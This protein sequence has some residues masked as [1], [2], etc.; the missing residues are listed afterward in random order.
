MLIREHEVKALIIGCTEELQNRV[1]NILNEFGFSSDCI[2][3]QNVLEYTKQFNYDLICFGQAIPHDGCFYLIK[4]IRT[5][6]ATNLIPIILLSQTKDEEIVNKCFT[7]GITE[8]FP[9][10]LDEDL[11]HSIRVFISQMT[12]VIHGRVLYIE[13]SATAAYVT[14]KMLK[15]LQLQ[16]S[17]FKSAEL[18]FESFKQ[19]SYDL[20]ITDILVEGNMS[21]IGLIREIRSLDDDKK[22]IPVLAV[23]GLE[24]V[25]R[26]IEIL[27][28]GANDFVQKPFMQEEF[29]ARISNLIMNKHLFDQVK[30]QQEELRRLSITDT[31]TGL[32]N[33]HYL[34]ESAQKFVSNAFRH[35]RPLSILMIDLDHFKA[36]NDTHG[37]DVGDSVLRETG[38]LLLNSC[39]DGDLIARFG[40][41]EFVMILPDC[42]LKF[43]LEKAEMIRQSFVTSK[44]ANL[45][46]TTSIGVATLT[47]DKSMDFQTL[48]KKADNAVY[49]AK[50]NGRNQV[51]SAQ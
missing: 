32:Y 35:Q 21:G 37:H 7:A 24:D 45:E 40:G 30:A 16:V 2:T 1:E 50:D 51:Q 22:E 25:A 42:Q 39:R 36:I 48:F 43:A 14:L 17:H 6:K 13:D 29:A 31:L 11:H 38:Q 19:E 28:Q 12:R 15:Q 18:A 3:N 34:F 27:R 5:N 26:R 46:V 33:R 44:P 41:E 9:H 49:A 47:L 10:G 8:V 4:Q 20:V 23:S